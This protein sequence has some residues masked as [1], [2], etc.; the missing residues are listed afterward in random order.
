VVKF[1]LFRIKEVCHDDD[2]DD[3]DD[4]DNDDKFKYDDH[5]ILL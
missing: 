2:G 5:D 1:L 3:D 4:D